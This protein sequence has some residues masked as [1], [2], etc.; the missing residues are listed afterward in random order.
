MFTLKDFLLQ[1][2]FTEPFVES[3][4]RVPSL[5]KAKN[6]ISNQTIQEHIQQNVSV[7]G[8]QKLFTTIQ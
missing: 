7:N 8:N 2:T 5:Q 3:S 6:L 4:K 1:T